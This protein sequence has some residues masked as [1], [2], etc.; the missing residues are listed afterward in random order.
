M[1]CSYWK[2]LPGSYF[3]LILRSRSKLA[4][5]VGGLP[6]LHPDVRHVDVGTVHIGPH[7][8]AELGDPG[9]GG[10]GGGVAASMNARIRLIAFLGNG[11]LVNCE[12]NFQFAGSSSVG[13]WNPA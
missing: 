3:A 11:L 8:L 12:K 13:I 4:P 1:L 9:L 10:R 5:P 6:F 7:C 2:T